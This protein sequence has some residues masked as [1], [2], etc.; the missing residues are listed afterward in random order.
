MIA[1]VEG[2]DPD[3]DEEELE[4]EKDE[5]TSG[6]LEDLQRRYEKEKEALLAQLRGS[7]SVLM[8]A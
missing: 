7:S 5:K 2:L 6:A 1:S 8:L 4:D 3:D